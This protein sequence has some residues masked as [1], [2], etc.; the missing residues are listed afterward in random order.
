M[1]RVL[2]TMGGIPGIQGGISHPGRHTRVYRE[3]YTTQGGY[4]GYTP[5]L[6]TPREAMLGIH[7][8]V[9]IERHTPG[10][11]PPYTHREAY[12]RVYTTVHTQGGIYPGLYLRRLS[13]A[14]YTRVYTSEG[15]REP[16]F[17]GINPGIRLSGAS[18]PGILTRV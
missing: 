6:Y 3:V 4:A 10:Y 16:L 2:P 8:P 14:S 9:H 17:P 13:G 15:S 11:I 18:L 5:L 1:Y 7:H 12:T